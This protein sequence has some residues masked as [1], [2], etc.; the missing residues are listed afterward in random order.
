MFSERKKK[1]IILTLA[2]S[3]ILLG[4][5][6][7][8]PGTLLIPV[9]REACDWLSYGPFLLFLIGLFFSVFLSIVAI[10]TTLFWKPGRR[11]LQVFV[12]LLS[13]I[14]FTYSSFWL[15]ATYVIMHFKP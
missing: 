2:L 1:A 8:H 6:T 13:V 5:V 12:I 14:G 3:S 9:S 10:T 7:M 4:W 15:F 11:L